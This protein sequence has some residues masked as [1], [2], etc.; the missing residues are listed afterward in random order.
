[1][2]IKNKILVFTLLGLLFISPYLKPIQADNTNSV[3]I[4]NLKV[5]PA[6]IKVGDTFAINVTLVNNS[7]NTIFVHN[8]CLSPFSVTFDNHATVDMKEICRWAAIQ[9]ILKPGE[10]MTVTGPGSNLAYRAI[11]AG[12]ENATITFSYGTKDASNSTSLS[13]SFLFTIYDS[14]T[15]TK[16]VNETPLKQV[17][18]GISPHDVKCNANMQLVFK[19]EDKSPACVKPQTVE[20]LVARGWAVTF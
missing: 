18:S 15:G 1:M 6:T 9:K 12:T 5:Q 16:T 10:N 17:K 7:T 3:G 14:N 2:K 20:K 4:L 11:T 19:T 8:D 13:K